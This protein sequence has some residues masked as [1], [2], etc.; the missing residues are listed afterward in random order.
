MGLLPKQLIYNP[1]VTVYQKTF[2]SFS[3]FLITYSKTCGQIYTIYTSN[4]A[5]SHKAML[6]DGFNDKNIVLGIKIRP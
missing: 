3:F 4:D 2:P 6:F 5:Y 1:L